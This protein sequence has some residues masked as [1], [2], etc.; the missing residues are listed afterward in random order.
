M[1][2][3][4]IEDLSY[5]EAKEA[6]IEEMNI[7]NHNCI[8]ADFD[9]G[10]GYSVL[11]FRNGRHIYHAN[12]YQLHHPEKTKEQ[13]K[14]LYIKKMNNILFTDE[15]LMEEVRTYSE[16][17]R[18]KYFLQNY[19]IQQYDYLSI[20]RFGK[21][22]EEN[23]E[24]A[25]PDYP[26]SN[27]I[28]FCYVKD[29]N[30]V[31]KQIKMNSHL[32]KEFKRI[33]KDNEIFREMIAYQ[34]SNYEACITHDYTEALAALGLTFEKLNTEKQKIVEQELKKQIQK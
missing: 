1:S 23:F 33:K 34:L 2:I 12:D 17:Q 13:L 22:Q 7:K 20:F 25:K 24:K 28:S 11:V 4:D 14:D 15:E 30:I 19:Y 26:Y 6:A 27:P 3:K 10:F 21:E 8:F 29:P 31:K 5:A 32:E 9:N 18:K 16:Y